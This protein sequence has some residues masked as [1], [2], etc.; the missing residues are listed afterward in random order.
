M[1]TARVPSSNLVLRNLL[2]GLGFHFVELT[3][4]PQLSLLQSPQD[5]GIHLDMRL[6]EESQAELLLAEAETAFQHSRFFRDPLVPRG[7]ASMRFR[8]W[9]RSS[10]AS[11]H[12]K[13]WIFFD[14]KGEPIAFFLDRAEGKDKFLEL[15]AILGKHRGQGVAKLVWQTY[16][17]HQRLQGVETINTNISAENSGVVALYPKLGFRF[18]EPSIAFHCHF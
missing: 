5:Y 13:T 2:Q 1:L 18:L 14:T 9:V 15:T 4:H 11:D 3:L 17:S 6:A 12:K 16:L 10:W 8:E 7:A